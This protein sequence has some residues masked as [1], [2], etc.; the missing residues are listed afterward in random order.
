MIV[1]IL[2]RVVDN[3]G[4]IGFVY[5]LARSLSELG[6]PPRLRVVV[7]DLA[8]FAA[9]CP[10]ID[11]ALPY[12][13]VNGWE[14]VRWNAPGEAIVRLYKAA[15]PRVAI[16]CYACGRPEWFEEILFDPSDGER[17]LLIDL[18]YFTVEQWSAEYHLLPSLTRSPHVQKAIFMPGI[19]PG[20]G[21]L[22]LD[23]RFAQA[24]A[25]ASA[26]AS[27]E[28]MRAAL[29]GEFSSVRPIADSWVSAYWVLVFS[30]EH[31]FESLVGD[32]AEFSRDRPVLAFAAAGRSSGPF[33]RAWGRAGAPFPVIPLPMLSQLLWD[34]LFAATD[35]AVIR[36][37]ESFSRAILA[38]RPFLWECYP[39]TES[40]GVTAGHLEKIRAFLEVFRQYADPV[41]FAVYE[42]LTL[43]FNRAGDDS[44]DLPP[45]SLPQGDAVL[46]GDLLRVLRAA[47]IGN[48]FRKLSQMARDRGNLAVNLMTFID[49]SL[50]NDS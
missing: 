5:R 8:S 13:T 18:E 36:G 10:G 43:R 11:P 16:E 42:K 2:C 44:P 6:D 3:L 46:P 31:D 19:L 26:Q 45:E 41:E 47:K 21:G 29:L 48:A 23:A 7:D 39:F 1:D 38:G 35:F 33:L 37:E 34:R 9:L 49:V 25:E 40:D 22:L 32:L 30:Y 28:S 12:Q 17:R 20:T 27:R 14:I 24:L 50:Y 4:D 15:P